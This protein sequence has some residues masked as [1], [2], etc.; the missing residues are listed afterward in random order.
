MLRFRRSSGVEHRQPV[1]PKQPAM[2]QAAV[3][4]R[5][6]WY[7]WA[8]GG[9]LAVLAVLAVTA[10]STLYLLWHENDRA[11][12]PADAGVLHV[13]TDPPGA[14]VSVD[15]EPRGSTPI[16]LKLPPGR[17]ALR[18]DRD[19]YQPAVAHVR[20][21]ARGDLEVSRRL[22]RDQPLVTPLH[23]P[24]PGLRIEVALADLRFEQVWTLLAALVLLVVAV[25]R[26][27]GR[28]R[29]PYVV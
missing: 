1:R 15:G 6:L 19:G 11:V 25:D 8:M 10:L 24:L 7:A 13:V 4:R 3:G 22:W 28:V 17:H 27:S 2:R 18:V 12:P 29:S 20:L 16:E 21:P 14:E 26:V 5:V 23:P 9:C